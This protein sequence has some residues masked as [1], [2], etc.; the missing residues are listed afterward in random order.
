MVIALFT[1]LLVTGCGKDE[2]KKEKVIGE[3]VKMFMS[4]KPGMSSLEV[5]D[6]FEKAEKEGLGKAEF[7]YDDMESTGDTGEWQFN[8]NKKDGEGKEET[9][10]I[11]ERTVGSS[12]VLAES[13]KNRCIE[14]HGA[15]VI[16]MFKQG[17]DG[18]KKVTGVMYRHDSDNEEMG[19]VMYSFDEGR[20]CDTE[21]IDESYSP[22][23]IDMSQKCSKEEVDK[24]LIDLTDGV[25]DEKDKK[26]KIKEIEKEEKEVWDREIG[27]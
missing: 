9:N 13:E 18:S 15:D 7:K 10:E 23:I 1:L 2:E 21:G 5:R 25:D 4:I 20:I 27:N 11:E 26:E 22:I 6:I 19:V 8:F 14:T 12:F 16:V 17:D 24:L 3:D